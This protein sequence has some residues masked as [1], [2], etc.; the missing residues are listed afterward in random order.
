VL[1]WWARRRVHI[2]SPILYLLAQP[3]S[4]ATSGP[5]TP[6]PTPIHRQASTP[7]GALTWTRSHMAS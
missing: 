3:P 4:P 6:T 5:L 1:T 2:P 7:G